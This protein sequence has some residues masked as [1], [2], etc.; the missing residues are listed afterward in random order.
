M[1]LGLLAVILTNG[2]GIF[3]PSRIEKL[4]LKDGSVLAGEPVQRQAIPNPG[5][6]DNLEKHRV[7]LKV[8][9]RDLY[10][11]DFKWIDESEIA[12]SEEPAGLYLVERSEYGPLIGTPA[13]VVE[14]DK[15]IAVGPEAVEAPAAGARREGRPGPGRREGDREGRDRGGE[16]H[17]RA[18]PARPPQAGLPPEAGPLARPVGRAPGPGQARAGAEGPLRRSSRRSWRSAWRRRAEPGS[19]SA[20][21]TGRRRSCGPST[22]TAP[23]RRTSCGGRGGRAS[24]RAASGASSRTSHARRTPRA[25]SSRPSSAP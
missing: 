22:S 24:T 13:K 17:P 8:G 7:Q 9:N 6:A 25:A 23:T 2:L 12:K 14:G 19:R 3:W 1:I 5:H 18:D 4:T 20:P 21:W 15:E 16:L 11:F 10:G